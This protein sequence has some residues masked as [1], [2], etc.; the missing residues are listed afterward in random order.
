L[1]AEIEILDSGWAGLQF[2]LMPN[3]IDRLISALRQIR[4]GDLG[5]FHF[6]CDDFSGAPGVADVQFSLMA[7]N[8]RENL[9]LE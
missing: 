4:E 9:V 7:P 6:R 5:H 1:R 2:R 8:D 3:D